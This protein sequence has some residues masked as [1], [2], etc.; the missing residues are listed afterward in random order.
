MNQPIALIQLISEETMQNLLPVLALRPGRLLHLVTPK[1]KGRSGP[2]AV[3]ARHSQIHVDPEPIHLPEMPT[4]RETFAATRSAMRRVSEAGALP[5]V[6]FTAGTKLM[7][8]GAFSS[9]PVW[10][11]PLPLAKAARL[12]HFFAFG[13]PALRQERLDQL[14]VAAHLETGE[15]LEPLARRNL[16]VSLQPISK[17]RYLAVRDA[18]FD[19]SVQEMA[20]QGRRNILPPDFRHRNR[21]ERRRRNRA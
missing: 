13:Q 4:I 2:I 8:I 14:T 3:A 6:N 19:S 9:Q 16:G 7:S 1:V 11:A 20:K 15:I 17:S 18:P 5:I 10:L 21:P 12:K